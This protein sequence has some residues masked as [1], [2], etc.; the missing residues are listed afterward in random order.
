MS[1]DHG[2][3][4]VST[5][6]QPSCSCSEQE[7]PHATSAAP[8]QF[9]DAGGCSPSTYDGSV[10]ISEIPPRRTQAQR[11]SESEEAL[12][13]AAAEV[14][15][16]RGIDRASLASI[17][18]RAGASRGLANHHFGS[19]DT[20]IARLARRTQDRIEA[21]QV[22][23]VGRHQR[24]IAGLSELDLLRL[25]VD[26]YFELFEHPTAELRAL[27]VMWGSTFP[28]KSPVEGMLEAERRS[29]D[30][31]AD[32]IRRGQQDRSIRTDVDPVAA[33]VVLHA[34]LR[35]VA[36]LRLTDSDVTDMTNVR[37]TCDAWIAGAL[38]PPAA[39][40]RRRQSGA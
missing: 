16:E 3:I 15:A 17:G 20:L 26:T 9:A 5:F 1:A 14:I 34:L 28:L 2:R 21:R 39:Q 30:G 23:A 12:L 33:A 6:W 40:A 32:I 25:I 11:R 7:H 36:A 27:L 24:M 29:Y 37:A 10:T 19:K 13:D 8:N 22:A 31:W 4:F 35:G 18:E 38:A